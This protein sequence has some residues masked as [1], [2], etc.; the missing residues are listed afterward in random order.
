MKLINNANRPRSTART[1][2]R[3]SGRPIIILNDGQVRDV[4]ERVWAELVALNQSEPFLFKHLKRLYRLVR[5]TS[6]VTV[7]PVNVD[8]LQ[9]IMVQALDWKKRSQRGE[10]VDAK[11]DEFVARMMLEQIH[12]SLPLITTIVR[13]KVFAGSGTLIDQPGMYCVDGVVFAGRL[14][15]RMEPPV[16]ALKH[17][18]E[19]ARQIVVQELLGDFPF[20]SQ[21]DRANA[22]GALLLPRVRLMINGP[23]PLHLIDAPAHGTG[24]SLLTDLMIAVG[25]GETPTPAPFPGSEEEIRKHISSAL[26]AD[27]ATV[28]F[29]NVDASKLKDG[30]ISSASLAAALTS[31]T[32]TDREL[33]KSRM[34]EIANYA[35]WLMTST[36]GRLSTELT[37]RTTLIR[38]NANLERPAGER[39]QPFRHPA[40]RQWVAERISDLEGALLTII[41]AWLSA[42]RPRGLRTLG[43]FESWSHVIG[44]ILD[45]AGIPGFLDNFEEFNALRDD[46]SDELRTFTG[47]WRD[48]F[49]EAAANPTQLNDLC[50]K[51]GLMY[52]ARGHTDRPQAQL[53][54]LG[55]QLRKLDGRI[56]DGK[57]IVLVKNGGRG[58]KNLYSIELVGSG[59]K[60]RREAHPNASSTGD[61]GDIFQGDRSGP[62]P[63]NNLYSTIQKTPTDVTDLT[64]IQDGSIV[65]GGDVHMDPLNSSEPWSPTRPEHQDGES[66]SKK[67]QVSDH[68]PQDPAGV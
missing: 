21:A 1:K 52:D 38:I 55:K 65:S 9:M 41:N 6:D 18:L 32:W 4:I 26:R 34:L 8:T 15:H 48:A 5:T 14:P 10:L 22:V 30:R 27:R 28:F 63:L 35:L 11:P 54:A 45:V 29:D 61:V 40:I 13:T 47:V 25:A 24:K 57:K 64:Q 39:A 23:T 62:P 68:C 31:T 7:G 36:N 58:H 37:R 33:G 46:E 66:S 49:G 43:S 12:P 20:V 51:H 56:I 42:G 44:G 67:P 17:Q 3:Q 53:S 60:Q 59:A 16:A 19:W 2:P 50:N